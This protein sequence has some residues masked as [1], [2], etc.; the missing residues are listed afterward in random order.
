MNNSPNKPAT[1]AGYQR[2]LA[3]NPRDARLFLWSVRIVT[4]GGS[5]TFYIFVFALLWPLIALFRG[6][7]AGT[8]GYLLHI[9]LWPLPS[10]ALMLAA[11]WL[12]RK[13]ARKYGFARE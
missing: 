10:F 6:A 13:I 2:I 1:G 5:A 8:G 3:E 7:W 4:V 11:A 12:N 9:V